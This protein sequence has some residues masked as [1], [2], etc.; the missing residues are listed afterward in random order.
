MLNRACWLIDKDC[1]SPL[2]MIGVC[3]VQAGLVCRC[4]PV[5][6][7]EPSSNAEFHS[8]VAIVGTAC[9]GVKRSIA[10]QEVKIA[11]TI[12]CWRTSAHPDAASRV[13]DGPHMVG[14]RVKNSTRY[15]RQRGCVIPDN[16]AVIRIVVLVR[17]PGDINNSIDQSETGPLMFVSRIERYLAAYHSVSSSGDG[18]GVVDRNGA[19]RLF[20]SVRQIQRV[21]ALEKREWTCNGRLADNVERVGAGIDDRRAGDTG[22]G[23]DIAKAS[24]YQAPGTGRHRS[25]TR[26]AAMSRVD[27]IGMPK[28]YARIRIAVGIKSVNAIVLCGD[29]D[30]VV[31]GAANGEVGDPQWL[32]VDGAVHA[33]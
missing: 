22:F 2:A 25:F 13:G 33:A 7:A 31:H 29:D 23:S 9:G 24:A 3:S 18:Y 28:R 1:S 5:R 8:A 27:Q 4:E 12:R 16:P 15:L 20:I 32:G 26:R 19:D 14:S 10:R 11:A 17:S 30:D 6:G 21:E